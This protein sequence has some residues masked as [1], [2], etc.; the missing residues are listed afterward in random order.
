[1]EAVCEVVPTARF[2]AVTGE[3]IQF[4]ISVEVL[5]VLNFV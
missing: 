3:K 2:K 5:N 4:K 1:M